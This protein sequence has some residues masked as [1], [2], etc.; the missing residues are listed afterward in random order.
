M[1]KQIILTM[2]LVIP[3]SLSACNTAHSDSATV[4]T[5]QESAASNQGQNPNKS[6]DP[7]SPELS[8]TMLGKVWR[9]FIEEGSYRL[10]NRADFQFPEW[11]IKHKL[12]PRKEDID[13]PFITS[14]IGYAGIVI[15]V[16]Q[17]DANRFGLVLVTSDEAAT[18]KENRHAVNWILRNKDLSRSALGASSG[19]LYVMEVGERGNYTT[20]EVGWDDHKRKYVFI[21]RYTNKV[22]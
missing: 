16:N 22:D 19:R 6:N 2:W 1:A 9:R 15:D 11:A 7:L 17:D 14:W 13:I 8:K 10:A 20:S 5:A 12:L 4:Q 3:L 18:D 21:K